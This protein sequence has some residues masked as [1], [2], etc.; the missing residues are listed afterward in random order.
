MIPTHPASVNRW[1]EQ[2]EVGRCA[3]GHAL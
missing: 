3:V 2:F 1:A